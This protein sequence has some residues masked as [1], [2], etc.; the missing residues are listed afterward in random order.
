MRITANNIEEL[1]D[2]I[3]KRIEI[4]RQRTTDRLKDKLDEYIDRYV[5]SYDNTWEGRSHS[6]YN[7]FSI[8]YDA[9]PNA[10]FQG[11]IGDTTGDNDFIFE[12]ESEYEYNLDAFD[13]GNNK[14]GKF[15]LSALVNYI[16]NGSDKNYYYANFPV[17]N[18]RPF[19]TKFQEYAQKHGTDIFL[20]ECNKLGLNLRKGSINMSARM[21]V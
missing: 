8:D 14:Y 10:D 20:A 4:A 13:H 18:A 2:Q 15:P 6:L 5:Y 7:A 19:K 9:Y 11:I 17:M 1:R 16:N 12:D 21:F 3:E